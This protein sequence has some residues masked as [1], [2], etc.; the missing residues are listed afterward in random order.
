MLHFLDKLTY[1]NKIMVHEQMS[2]INVY[3][4]DLEQMLLFHFTETMPNTCVV[5]GHVKGKGSKVSMHRFPSNESKRQ[6]WLK[7]LNISN[8]SV[9]ENTRICSKHFLYADTSNVPSIDIGRRFS[10]PKKGATARGI[11]CTRRS[12]DLQSPPPPKKKCQQ[13][14]PPRNHPPVSSTPGSSAT[15]DDRRSLSA[16]IGEPLVSDFRVHELPGCDESHDVVLDAALSARIDVLEAE[17]T[18]LR[19]VPNKQRF[20]RIEQISGQDSLVRFYSGFASFEVLLLFFNFLGPAAHRLQYWGDKERKTTRRRKQLKLAPINQF[21]LTLVKLRL[22]LGVKDLAF[23]FGISVGLASKYFATWVCFLYQHLKEIDWTPSTEQ[24]AATLPV[25]FKDKYPSTYC[26][27]DASEIFLETATDLFM[28][29]STWSNYKHHNTAKV[30]VCCTPNGC[31]SYISPLYVGGISDVEL[32]K[33]SGFLNTLDG[34]CGVSVMA[35]RGFTVR[36]VL[37]QKGVSLNIPPFMEGRRQLPP[38][39]IQKG[40]QIASLRIHVERSIGR[41]KTYKIL[42]GNFPLS[43][44]RIANQIVSVCAWL[45]NFQPALIPLPADSSEDDVD[46]YFKSVLLSDTETE[47]DADCELS[48]NEGF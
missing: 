5:C 25:G 23:R 29:S 40:R 19:S 30:L 14:T 34:K 17:V 41:I 3:E 42:G 12:T 31:I 43:M 47:Y 18:Q 38:E 45:T 2:C 22:N 15:D 13:T 44:I 20:F 28:Q 46:N 33:V 36:D 27:I 9:T 11:R 1:T 35:D 32:T 10:S 7:A 39:E 21:F 4:I 8:E 48:D 16:S 26:I 24:V 37:K 6:E